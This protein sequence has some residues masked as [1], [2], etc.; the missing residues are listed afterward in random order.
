MTQRYNIQPYCASA[1]EPRSYGFD[2]HAGRRKTN[3]KHS[4][5]IVTDRGSDGLERLPSDCDTDE[6]VLQ[7]CG[8]LFATQGDIQGIL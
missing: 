5:D 6:T 3:G 8:G 7:T 4:H 1:E 2:S